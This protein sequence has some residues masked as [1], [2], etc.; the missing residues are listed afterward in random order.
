MEAVKQE[1]LRECQYKDNV[2]FTAKISKQTNCCCDACFRLGRVMKIVMPETK[3]FDRKELSTKYYMTWLCDECL[4]KLK[5]A[6]GHP[7][8]EK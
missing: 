3:Y 2:K 4:E 7:K 5:Y 8:E 1:A 6:L